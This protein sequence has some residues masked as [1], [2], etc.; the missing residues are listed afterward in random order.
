MAHELAEGVVGHADGARVVANPDGGEAGGAPGQQHV[1][2]HRR[3]VVVGEG[4]AQPGAEGAKGADLA[5]HLRPHRRLQDELCHLRGQV[6]PQAMLLLLG[7]AVHDIIALVQPGQQRAD[8]LR[9]VLEVIVHGHQ[10]GVR[11]Q[12]DAAQQSV[13]LAVVAHQI[14]PA[15]PGIAPRQALDRGPASVAAA[16]VDQDR[17]IARSQGG[18]DS[19]QPGQQWLQAVLAVV[20]R[21]DNRYASRE[22]SRRGHRL[23]ACTTL[24]LPRGGL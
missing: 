23:S 18:Q 8:L 22:R 4:V 10:R 20:D 17:L 11:R 2:R 5:G 21:D 7:R 19:G 15:H 14:H 24:E 3:A 13:M 1:N 16:I 6:A 9:R 12:P